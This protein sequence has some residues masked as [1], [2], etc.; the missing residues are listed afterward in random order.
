MSPF[1]SRRWHRAIILFTAL[2]ILAIITEFGIGWFYQ[3]IRAHKKLSWSADELRTYLTYT[4]RWDL[5]RLERGEPKVLSYYI[6][7]SNGRVI[8]LQQFNPAMKLRVKA[9]MPPIGLQT[10]YVQETGQ[11][12]RIFVKHIR[13]CTIIIGIEPPEDITN[14]DNRLLGDAALFGTTIESALRVKIEQTDRYT[15]FAIVDDKMNVRFAVGGIPLLIEPSRT[16]KFNHFNEIPTEDGLTYSVFTSPVLSNSGQLVGVISTFD[17]AD[18]KPWFSLLYWIINCLSSTVLAFIGTLIGIPYIGEKF[19]P[20]VLLH[21][22]LQKGES[23]T[24]EFKESL[25]WSVWQKTGKQGDGALKK[26]SEE[27]A[28]ETV[29][30][31]LN[32]PSGGTLLIGVSDDK[33]IVGLERD[34]ESLAQKGDS[35]DDKEKK[36]DRFQVHFRNLLA[37]RIGRDTTNLYIQSAFVEDDGKDVCVLHARPAFVPIYITDG[38][39]K[40]F[41]VRDGASTVQLDVE[42]TVA[43]VEK[44]WPKALWRRGWNMIRRW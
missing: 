43:F 1:G 33:K 10:V 26:L 9:D 37:Q 12:W 25:R 4:D 41:F 3:Y 38:K 18:P 17:E 36:Q 34:Y 19:E 8:D 11:T 44:R 32:Q 22:S 29:A 24:V 14:V 35:R 27:I 13:G 23:W 31:F 39:A 30:A 16:L 21:D 42:Q 7:D 6:L 15:Q 5:E 28:V 2:F 40:A 20:L